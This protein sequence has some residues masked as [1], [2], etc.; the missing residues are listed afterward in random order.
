MVLG[1]CLPVDIAATEEADVSVLAA[2]GLCCCDSGVEAGL[3]S[4]RRQT[5]WRGEAP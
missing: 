3:A 4:M 2:L 5:C 1:R